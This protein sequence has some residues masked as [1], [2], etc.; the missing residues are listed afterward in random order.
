MYRLASHEYARQLKTD[1]IEK[2]DGQRKVS[3]QEGHAPARL[4]QLGEWP[5]HKVAAFEMAAGNM[6]HGLLTC[7]CAW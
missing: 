7:R 5:S 1:R 2:L 6:M 3:E 4:K